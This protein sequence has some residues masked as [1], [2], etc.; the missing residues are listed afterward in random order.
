MSNQALDNQVDELLKNKC[1][2]RCGMDIVGFLYCT[3][4]R[5]AE[6]A[7]KILSDG[8]L[9]DNTCRANFLLDICMKIEHAKQF[10]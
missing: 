9:P 3:T 7:S 1:D 5:L 4:I 8:Y 2:M 6:E 10:F